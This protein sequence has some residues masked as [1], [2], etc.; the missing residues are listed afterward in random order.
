MSLADTI[1]GIKGG[2]KDAY[3]VAQKHWDSIAKPLNGLGYLEDMVCR[4]AMALG[5]TPID[6]S[7][8]TLAVFCADNGVVEEGISQSGQEI[9]ALV[10]RN[11]CEGSTSVCRMAEVAH[12]AVTPIDVGM[13][14]DVDHPHMRCDKQIYSTANFAKRPA[15]TL[16][17]TEQTIEAGI[18]LAK[19]LSCEGNTLLLAGEMGIGNTTTSSAVASVLL[20]VPVKEVTGYG[21]GLSEKMLRHKVTT[22]E[23]AIENLNPDARDALDVLAK[24]GGADIAAM[25]GFYLGAAEHK[26]PVLLDGF[27]SGVAALCAVRLNPTVLDYLIASHISTEPGGRIVLET[28]GLDAPIQASLHLGEGSGAVAG[29]PLLDMACAVY[30]Q[31]KSFSESD[32][33]PYMPWES[34]DA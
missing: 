17:Q 27:I 2:D 18:R 25:C 1:R 16:K 31:A 15:L 34:V 3:R 14:V 19:Q 9:T 20:G 30:N 21:S 10:A 23:H 6:I 28:L 11:L 22:I 12:C 33:E 7:K 26:T 5:S 13:A 24:V 32:I 29:L 4:I 8:R